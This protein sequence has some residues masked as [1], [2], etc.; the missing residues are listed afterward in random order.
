MAKE[1]AMVV[2]ASGSST[3]H[4]RCSTGTLVG[5]S[6]QQAWDL[7]EEAGSVLLEEV[8]RAGQGLVIA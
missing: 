6:A 3:E 7:Y 5:D 8:I 1:A 4:A 2:P